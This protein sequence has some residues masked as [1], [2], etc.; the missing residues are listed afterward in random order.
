M[1]IVPKPMTVG[2]CAEPVTK[3][4]AFDYRFS[5]PWADCSQATWMTATSI[6]LWTCSG[7]NVQV[8]CFA[9]RE[10][11]Y[12]SILPDGS[13]ENAEYRQSMI[14]WLGLENVARTN[15]HLFAKALEVTP[16]DFSPFGP[17]RETAFKF[18]LFLMKTVCMPS[19]AHEIYSFEHGD[20][21]GIQFGNPSIDRR[22]QLYLFDRMER[23]VQ[24]VVQVSTNSLVPLTQ[25]D[26]NTI[27]TTF[28]SEP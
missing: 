15:F 19:K 8:V 26:I 20:I 23:E 28:S 24:L 25:A 27:I 2:L 1:D 9:P 18:M 10:S 22:A 16:G 6:V 14:K 12:S 13:S 4:E 11:L 5:A 21:K 7:S 3:L 17:R